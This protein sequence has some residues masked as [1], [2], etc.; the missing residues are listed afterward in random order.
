MRATRSPQVVCGTYHAGERLA[1][2]FVRNCARI[3]RSVALTAL[4]AVAHVIAAAAILPGTAAAKDPS[5]VTQK[6]SGFS[7][8]I[9]G[10]AATSPSAFP[11]KNGNPFGKIKP[12]DKTQPLNLQGDQLIYDTNSNSVIAR[13]N[14]AR[15][16]Q[17]IASASAAMSGSPGI[18][19]GRNPAARLQGSRPSG[20]ST[21]PVN[22]RP[23]DPDA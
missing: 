14:A 9:D 1:W 19:R 21:L 23:P 11:A 6:Y 2:A 18:R 5:T 15:S 8:T 13:G 7:N 4:M 10:G 22:S 20:R 3:A 17:R 12:P 16:P